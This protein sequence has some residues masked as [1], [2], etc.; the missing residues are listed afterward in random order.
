MVKSNGQQLIKMMSE[1]GGTPSDYSD[2]VFGTVLKVKPLEVQLANDMVL[3][4]DFLL[5]G[6]HIGKFKVQGKA[7]FKGKQKMSF[8]GHTRDADIS[9]AEVSFPKKEKMYIEVDNSLEKGDKLM[10]IRLDGGQQYYILERI[11][12]NDEYGF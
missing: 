9:A 11:D 3:T 10:L 12:K 7:V 2:I 5:L 8:H 6:K 1:R 4:E